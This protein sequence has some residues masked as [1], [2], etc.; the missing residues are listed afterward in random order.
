MA[1]Y[2]SLP[3]TAALVAFLAWTY[4]NARNVHNTALVPPIIPVIA[5]AAV[6]VVGW[7]IRERFEGWAFV[8]T[9]V[10]IVATVATIF[11][12]L[13]PRVMVS[14]ISP[15]YDLT[16][17]N[18]SS[19][20]YTL[21]VMTIVACIFTPLVLLYQ[22]WTFYTFRRRLQRPTPPEAV[23]ANDEAPVPAD[24][25]GDGLAQTDIP[26]GIAHGDDRA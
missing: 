16:I 18:A 21:K 7:L 17:G 24:D 20:P 4:V 23:D 3:S 19:A 13:F 10:A 14:S 15:A 6:A 25:Q 9:A 11:L 22:G 2:L 26:G 5:I 1:G 8:A 12:N